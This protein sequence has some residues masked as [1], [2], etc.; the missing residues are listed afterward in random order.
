MDRRGYRTAACAR[1]RI[2][3][4]CWKKCE[5]TFAASGCPRAFYSVCVF[6][7]RFDE[8]AP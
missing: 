1:E 5:Q 7:G 3:R 4:A 2:W 8:G 6:V